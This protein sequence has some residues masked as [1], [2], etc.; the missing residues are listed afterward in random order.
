MR[1]VVVT[2]GTPSQVGNAVTS[3]QLE[4]GS[5]NAVASA[6]AAYLSAFPVNVTRTTGV[7]WPSIIA[8][9]EAHKDDHGNA[10][11]S[12]AAERAVATGLDGRW[13]AL[14]QA[15]VEGNLEIVDQLLDLGV[16][17]NACSQSH[18]EQYRAPL[19]ACAFL[20]PSMSV[21]LASKLLEKGKAR[22]TSYTTMA[23]CQAGNLDFFRMLLGAPY[24]Q[25]QTLPLP[26]ELEKLAL[27][28]LAEGRPGAPRE[29][30]DEED[31]KGI[32]NILLNGRSR[33]HLPPTHE[34]RSRIAEGSTCEEERA[35][36]SELA[37]ENGRMSLAAMLRT[38]FV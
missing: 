30:S 10:T 25:T 26:P 7:N 20:S 5:E 16:D 31:R 6:L 9:L 23:A 14:S 1:S 13:P 36:P 3:I 4:Q 32:A 15:V 21:K 17:P 29:A 35:L 38:C 33:F 37:D 12:Q 19:A 27:V 22:A 28:L 8:L 34:G 2:R 18:R 24:D 11:D